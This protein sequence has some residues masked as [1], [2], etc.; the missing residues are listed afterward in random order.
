MENP[1]RGKSS[2]IEGSLVKPIELWKLDTLNESQSL[3][4]SRSLDYAHKVPYYTGYN[5]DLIN[6]K[7]IWRL[8][9]DKPTDLSYREIFTTSYDP[10]TDIWKPI[11]QV[12]NTTEIT[13]DFYQSSIPSFSYS[14]ALVGLILSTVVLRET[15]AVKDP[16]KS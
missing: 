8:F 2:V 7:G 6:D 4:S 11:T 12:T 14:V 10:S 1:F 15:R 9:W 5:T 16:K 13:D 3:V